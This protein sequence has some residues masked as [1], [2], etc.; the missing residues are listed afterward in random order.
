MFQKKE[1]PA[2]VGC[3]PQA[4]ATQ[5]CGP[6]ACAT[7]PGSQACATQPCATNVCEPSCAAPVAKKKGLFSWMQ[8]DEKK[9]VGCATEPTCAYPSQ[10]CAT[11]PVC[12]SKPAACTTSPVSVGK[13]VC[14]PQACG[15]ANGCVTNGCATTACGT[16]C[17]PVGYPVKRVDVHP[18]P[19][20]APKHVVPNGGAVAPK[21]EA[22]PAEGGEKNA[23][24]LPPAPPEKGAFYPTQLDNRQSSRTDV[25][26][27]RLADLFGLP[28]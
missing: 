11:T 16:V 6:Q 20:G 26:R 8:K 9:P 5:P 4:C 21:P 13:P 17:G 2:A 23:Q 15:S 24:P 28:N 27:D 14:G 12:V 3:A 22:V 18:A 19:H 10:A 7:R 25:Q 1:K